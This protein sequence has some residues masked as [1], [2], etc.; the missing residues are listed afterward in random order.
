LDPYGTAAV[1]LH[2]AVQAVEEGGLLCITCTDKAVLCGNNSETCYGK[3]GSMPLRGPFCHEQALRIL[4]SLTER[5]ANLSRRYIVPLVSMSIDFYVRVF[6]R[7]YTSPAQV[8][9][10]ASKQSMVFQ[11]IGCGSF[12]TSA[13]GK[14]TE[15]GPSI[16]FTPGMGPSTDHLCVECKRPF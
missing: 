5:T 16:K 12:T 2:A 6:V 14:V 1:F 8:K 3:Y 11:C 4:L 10:S 15:K 13:I 9:R 7:V